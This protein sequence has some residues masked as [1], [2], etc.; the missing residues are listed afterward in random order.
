MPSA[1]SDSDRRLDQRLP[2]EMAG[3][4]RFLGR[5]CGRS[6][7]V[8]DL[9]QD[10]LTRSLSY[11][12]SF[13]PDAELGPWLRRIALRCYLDQRRA[14]QRPSPTVGLDANAW[15]DP[16]QSQVEAQL[17]LERLVNHGEF[18]ELSEAKKLERLKGVSASLAH[19]L[20]SFIQPALLRNEDVQIVG[21]SHLVATAR[22]EQHAWIVR[23]LEGQ[24]LR[25]PEQIFIETKI[26]TIEALRFASL[27][28]GDQP[29]IFSG[30]AEL[31]NFRKSLAEDNDGIIDE[32]IAPKLI[33]FGL[34]DFQMYV[35]K[36]I[37]YVKDFDV[38]IVDGAI[39]ADPVLETIEDGIRF[40]GRVVNLGDGVIGVFC[41]LTLT[42]VEQP[43]QIVEIELGDT[44]LKGEIQLPKIEKLEI[45][46]TAVI[47]DSGAAIFPGPEIDGRHTLVL[48]SV[49]VIKG[50]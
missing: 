36:P 13:R 44:G 24:R 50:R 49:K 9:L 6:D 8:D 43:I 5:L 14:A 40:G 11:Q 48:I 1:S 38:E 32:V 4:R 18:E 27:E 34:Q 29:R 17:D 41:K 46:A 2:A 28:I 22:P 35:T 21:G 42:K 45:D 10:T 31:E 23:F 15:P 47:P 20:R 30:G 19:C 3:L 33:T 7:L 12:G 25:L 16:R 26:L 39:L 37:T